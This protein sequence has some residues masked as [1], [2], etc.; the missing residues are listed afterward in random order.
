MGAAAMVRQIGDTMTEEQIER[1][2]ERRMN[3]LDRNYIVGNINQD[4]YDQLVKDLDDWAKDE[5]RKLKG[6]RK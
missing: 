2:A 5:Y 1:I 6:A 3:M 4:Q